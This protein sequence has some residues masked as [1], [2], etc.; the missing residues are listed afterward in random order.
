MDYFEIFLFELWLM[1]VLSAVSRL[2][3]MAGEEIVTEKLFRGFGEHFLNYIDSPFFF[4]P[5]SK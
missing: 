2:T 4:L 1:L 3:M 5:F